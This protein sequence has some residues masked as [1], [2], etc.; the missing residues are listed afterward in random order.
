MAQVV[1]DRLQK[2]SQLV[3]LA[4]LVVSTHSHN[5]VIEAVHDVVDL[6]LIDLS[7]KLAGLYLTEQI[8]YPEESLA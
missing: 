2:L 1:D 8:L 5:R 4:C 6:D 3:V 7:L